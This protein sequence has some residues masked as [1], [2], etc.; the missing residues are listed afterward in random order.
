[1]LLKIMSGE[2]APDSDSRKTFQL[3]DGVL[4]VHFKRD[5]DKAAAVKVVFDNGD[6]PE[7]FK[8]VGNCYLMNGDG[9]TIAS[10]GPMA[11]A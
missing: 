5:K 9:K 2:N 7:T 8:L 4:S 11:L 6:D 1:M 10:F 3:L